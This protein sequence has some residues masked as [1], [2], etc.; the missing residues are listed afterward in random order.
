MA[1]NNKKQSKNQSYLTALFAASQ[2]RRFVALAAVLLVFSAAFA[3]FATLREAQPSSRAGSAALP[4]DLPTNATLKASNKKVF[5]HYF[6]P[7]PISLDNK[8]STADYYTNNYLNPNGESGKHAAYGGLLR[9]RPLARAPI[10][11][12]Y[13][14]EDM[15]TEIRRATEAGLDGFTVDML[16]LSGAH[17][18]RLNLLLQAAPQVDSS[19]KIVLMPDSNSSA[20]NDAAALAASI[21]S[22]AK[23]PAVYKL[24]DGRL[25]VS[26]FYP[27]KR[28][29]AYWQNF[30]NIMKNQYGV[31]VAFVPCF[32]NYG[33]NAAAFAP[34][35]YGF[36]NW[37]NR[38][39]AANASLAGNIADAHAKGKIWMQPVSVQDS[40]PNQSI[41]DEAN[42]TENLRKT[43]DAA[44]AGADWVQ[45]PTWNDYS[46][47]TQFSPSSS[48]GWGPLDISSYYVTRFK[49]GAWPAL[50]RDVLV[51]SH[52]TQP[53]GAKPTG[54]QT[55]LMAL[56]SGSSPARD[57]VE[58]LSFLP[59][60]GT[61]Q[62]KVGANTYSYSAPAGMSAK[63]YPLAAGAVSASLSRSGQ[64]YTDV[65]SPFGVTNSPAV[66]DL[67]YHYV[68]STRNG[69]TYAVSPAP[70]PTPTPTPT[71]SPTPTPTPSPTPV[72]PPSTGGGTTPIVITPGGASAQPIVTNGE[73]IVIKPEN[74]TD[75]INVSINGKPVENNTIK[76]A[77]LT[78]G[79]HTV[80]I[81]ENGKVTTQDIEVKNPMPRAALNEVKSKPALYGSGFF[82][83]VATIGFAVRWAMVGKFFF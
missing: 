20:T 11:S 26:P 65:S 5:A 48:V 63:T 17:W 53:A 64:T 60:A 29:A 57:T 38:N 78:N 74:P 70:T 3:G 32:L 4:F 73:E 27:E 23:S 36:S 35:S 44:I 2:R 71:P 49:T 18:D 34:F 43:W 72:T 45:L 24:G 40:R 77:D 69:K 61:I 19:F 33:A 22:I 59:T 76:T 81:E 52:R 8:V 58:V 47:G 80:T 1:V 28:G 51:V 46:E 13:Q 82:A 7:Y 50:K 75:T 83:V 14:L 39:P 54:G 42:N 41:Y 6:T 62:V 68:T 55:K 12:N 30:I 25:V 67:T 79:K 66:Q 31:Q 16:G 21:A 37:G 9:D 56:R 10:A 15:K